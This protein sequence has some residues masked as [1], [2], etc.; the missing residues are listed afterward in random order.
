MKNRSHRMALMARSIFLATVALLA[1][2][3]CAGEPKGF[4]LDGERFKF[5][6]GELSF[7]GVLIKPS[8]KGPFAA[9]LISH[10]LGGNGERMGRVMA[11]DF[12]R[13]GF[14]CISPDYTHSNPR[15]DRKTFGASAENIKR[16]KKCLDI[17]QSLS[18]VDSKKLYA[19]GNSMGAF[20]TIGLAAE[21]SDR[22]VAAAITAGGINSVAGFAAPS[23]TQATKKSKIP[24]CILHGSD[25]TTVPPEKSKLL[26]EVLKQN[27][28]PCDR[29]V[30]DGVG[31]NLNG[32]KGRE[33]NEKIE[34]WFAKYSKKAE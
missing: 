11:R 4:K 3:V 23:K 1:P 13:H 24:F 29:I 15:G 9:V 21:E 10:G 5:D 27:K 31:H 30:F 14:V 18:E 19:Y 8:G 12:V 34:A 25:D 7:S 6:D 20:L 22:L 17:L 33:V 26:E 28:V 32:A 16:A 2:G